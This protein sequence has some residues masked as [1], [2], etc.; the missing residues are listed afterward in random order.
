VVVP[1]VKAVEP[2]VMAVAK[3]VSNWDSG[4]ADVAVAKV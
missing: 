2:S 4:I 3:L 1:K